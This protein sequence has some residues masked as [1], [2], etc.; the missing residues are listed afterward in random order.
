MKMK[1]LVNYIKKQDEI[2]NVY[3]LN[4]DYAHGKQWAKYG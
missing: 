2:K 4:Q 1:P 3:L